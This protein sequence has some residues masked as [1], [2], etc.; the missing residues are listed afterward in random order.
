VNGAS[1]PRFS[2]ATYRDIDGEHVALVL[3]DGLMEVNQAVDLFLKLTAGEAPGH[4]NPSSMVEL[5]E[6][7][8]TYLPLLRGAAA[9][10]CG[11]EHRADLFPRE[12][13]YLLAPIPQPGKLVNV[14]LNFYDHAAEMG[15]IVPAEGFVPNFFLK[16]DRNCIIGPSQTIRLSSPYVDWEAEL[17]LVIGRTARNVAA[18]EALD[19]VAGYMC[20]NDLTD[21]RLMIRPD[22]S[23][24]FFGGKSRETFGP[25]GPYLVPREFVPDPRNLGIRCYVN[26]QLMQHTNT[27]Y[28]IWGPEQ[29]V[30][31]LS[32]I[33]TL[34]PGDVIA[35][36]TGA[37]VGWSKGLEGELRSIARIVAHMES[38]GGV[39]L[40]SGDSVAVEVDGVGR[41]ENLVE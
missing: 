10:L 33:V 11:S 17:A 38:G 21:R 3:D 13:A 12:E 39:Y 26:D 14:G 40:R 31:Y 5:L 20:H 4:V 1:G 32:G 35:L 15:V 22:G 36:G 7:W 2:L 18:E 19:Y 25:L 41:L 9:L 24:D 27:G 8:D 37:G 23:L 28:A 6:R 34:R 16:G 29:C 30:E